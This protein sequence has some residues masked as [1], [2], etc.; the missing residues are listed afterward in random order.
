MALSITQ[1]I[2]LRAPQYSADTRLPDFIEL[3]ELQTSSGFGAKYNY[4]VALRV[5]HMLTLETI[6]G[7]L[8]SASTSGS[9][10]AGIITSEAEG[11]LSRSYGDTAAVSGAGGAGRYV[12]LS[13]TAY[14][15]ELI[16]LING[17]FFKPRTRMMS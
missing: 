11:D 15:T 6:H 7:G 14:G 10:V 1:I 16:E 12:N 17:T 3:A 9:A 4:A 13:T 8:I 5:L 2:T